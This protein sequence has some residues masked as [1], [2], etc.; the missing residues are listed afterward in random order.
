MAIIPKG[1]SDRFPGLHGVQEVGGS[2]PLAP[3]KQDITRLYLVMSF[4]K[5]LR[6]STGVEDSQFPR[7]DVAG[8]DR[9]RIGVAQTPGKQF[10]Q[11][12]AIIGGDGKVGVIV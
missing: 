11:H 3:T 8:K 10:A 1:K 9:R 7:G 6:P 4:F 2:N 12:L 5:R